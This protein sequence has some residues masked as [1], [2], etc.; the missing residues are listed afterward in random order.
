MAIVSYE[1][2]LAPR[3]WLVAFG[4]VV[5]R[6]AA[7]AV[8]MLTLAPAQARAQTTAVEVSMTGGGSTQEVGAAATQEG[9]WGRRSTNGTDAFGGAYPYDDRVKLSEAYGEKLVSGNRF[10]GA[11]RVGRYR[12]PFGLY[13]KSDHAYTGFLRAPLIRYDGYFA[14]SN[15]FLEG[16]VNLLGGVPHFQ[17]EASLGV[18]QDMGEAVR[19]S[20][21]DGVV[22]AQFHRGNVIIGVS[23]IRHKPYERRSFAR[24]N[25]EFTG[26]D[27]RWMSSGIQVRGEW[28]TGRPWD[29]VSTDGWYVDL[30]VHKRPLGPVT[31][32]FRGEDLD[33]PAYARARSPGACSSRQATR[34]ST[35]RRPTRP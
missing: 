27:F 3:S 4:P 29:G 20:G 16:A 17:I 28:L 31:L 11:V 24:G 23:H 1:A 34:C 5:F 10:M 19:R 13:N 6:S 26:V 22:R 30:L 25:A 18:P 15:N 33:Y 7:T 8:A 35:Q 9:T 14:I 21:L 2:L 12:T 32:V